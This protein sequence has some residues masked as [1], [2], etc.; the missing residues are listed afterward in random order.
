MIPRTIFRKYNPFECILIEKINA[1]STTIFVNFGNVICTTPTSI[2]K[3]A[4]IFVPKTSIKKSGSG[5]ISIE[6]GGTDITGIGTQFSLDFKVGDKIS[7]GD[8]KLTVTEISSDTSMKTTPAQEAIAGQSYENLKVYYLQKIEEKSL[9]ESNIINANSDKGSI[10]LKILFQDINKILEEKCKE[11]QQSLFTKS[12]TLFKNYIDKYQTNLYISG[13]IAKNLN[14]ID[15]SDSKL[16][17]QQKELFPKYF[18]Y[19]KPGDA[20]FENIKKD[21][22][23]DLD[24]EISRVNGSAGNDIWKPELSE[25]YSLLNPN[26]LQGTGIY[27]NSPLDYLMDVNLTPFLNS[28]CPIFDVGIEFIPFTEETIELEERLDKYNFI[29]TE[30]DQKFKLIPIAYI[31]TSRNEIIEQIIDFDYVFSFPFYF[32]QESIVDFI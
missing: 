13:N 11:W 20:D 32:N 28:S 3:S 7:S 4:N 30:D 17:L 9:A 14:T 27:P 12:T 10:C 29:Q 26:D 18:L 16:G 2:E 23:K 24:Q 25:F 5:T 19:T 31:D 15:L 6:E 22:K 21:W 8:Q 1:Q